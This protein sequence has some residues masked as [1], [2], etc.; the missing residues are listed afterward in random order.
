MIDLTDLDVQVGTPAL[1]E[2]G[3]WQVSPLGGPAQAVD[4]PGDRFALS[5]TVPPMDIEPYGRRWIADLTVARKEG[6]FFAFPQVEFDVGAPGNTLVSGAVSGGQSLP[7]RGG[8][9]AYAIRKGQWLSIIHGGR[10]YLHFARAQ[11]ILDAAGAGALPIFP[12]LRTN[13]VDGDVIELARP[14]I[15]GRLDG[16]EHSWTLD[17]ARNVGLQFRIVEIA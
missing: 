13:L 6:C 7:I 4:F 3:G 5:I 17:E 12:R 15:E 2:F 9:A 11:L 8:T 16:D 1:I 10:R 14:I